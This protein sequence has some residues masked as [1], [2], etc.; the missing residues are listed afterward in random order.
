M[1]VTPWV[2]LLLALYPRAPYRACLERRAPAIASQVAAA[3]GVPPSLLVAVGWHESHL[4]CAPRSG[5]CWGAPVSRSRR[6]TAGGV[7][8]AASSL[9]TGYRVCGTWAGAV[10][11]FRG[12]QC[13]PGAHAAYVARVLALAARLP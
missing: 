4:G 9:A 7:S 2:A 10:A 11:R 3:H 5:G 6:G 8:E 1:A 13:A 12:G